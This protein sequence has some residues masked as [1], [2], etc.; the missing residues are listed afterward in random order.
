M[1]SFSKSSIKAK[2]SAS[3]AIS[4]A[5]IVAVATVALVELWGLNAMSARLTENW[6][7]EMESLGQTKRA[8]DEH[9]VLLEGRIS[10][11]NF[12]QIAFEQAKMADVRTRVDE[13]IRAFAAVADDHEEQVVIERFRADWKNYLA[14]YHRVIDRLDA[15]D[16]RGARAEFDSTTRATIASVYKTLDELIVASR[17]EGA[18]AAERV[19]SVFWLSLALILGIMLLGGLIVVAAIHWISSNV[20][21][22]ILNISNAMRR[23]AQGDES[24]A[25]TDGIGRVDE[26]GVLGAA[27]S[28]YRESLIRIRHLAEETS[29]ERDRLDTALANMSQGLCM[30]DRDGRLVIF[31]ERFIEIYG[32]PAGKIAAGMTTREIMELS[33]LSSKVTDADPEATLRLRDTIVREGK[34]GVF[35]QRLTDGRSVSISYRPR[36]QGG[37]VV[38]FEDITEHLRAEE[39]IRHLAQFDALTDLPNRVTFYEAIDATLTHLRRADSTAILSLDLDHFKSVNDTLGHP[40]GD[41]LLK[42]AAERMRSCVRG[43]DI[44]ARLGGDEFAIVQVPA[45]DAT[46]VTALAARLIEAVGAPYDIDG[47]QVVVGVSIG[48]AIAPNDGH[49]P[50]VLMKNADLAL[51]RAKAD[52]GGAYRFF[53]TEMDARMQA[54]RALELDLRKAVV[55]GEFE[56]YY[57]PIVDVKTQQITSCEALVRWHHPERGIVAPME[58]I[59]LA[60]ETSLIVPIGE[61]VLRQAC[62]EAAGWPAHVTVAVNLSPAQ[63]KSHGLVQTVTSALAD[64]RLPP[65][66]LE[67]EI[68]ELVLLQDN[69]GTFAILHEL[70]DLGIRIAMDDFGTG[71]S[72]LGYL[73]S[74]PFSKI[75]IDK[76]F[77]QDL[78]LKEDSIAIIRAVVGLGSSMGITTTAEGVETKDQFV[79]LASEGCNEVQGFLF[80]EPRPS[81]EIIGLIN[82]LTP[83]LADVA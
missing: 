41:S 18:E 54:R 52:G 25:V 72:S 28:G 59:P 60:E 48:I 50:D 6:L 65:G 13:G 14:S 11:T 45:Q 9:Q 56:L 21:K 19:Q 37:F 63:F 30:F 4:L 12:R 22:P 66:R 68:T 7:P 62:T 24:V 17:A 79:R 70:R 46:S 35:V 74:F 78:P 53:E 33:A 40:V 47:H 2:L 61:W 23:L 15:G 31:N 1:Q 43:D 34:S 39:R 8:I 64:S 3:F 42:A 80:S 83:Q 29:T 58:F 71:Y 81:N 69:N 49:E 38:T 36:P 26:I 27:V 82:K 57:Q 77:V 51:Y 5:L 44:V 32:L 67:L 73:R 20:S 55:N 75:K 76:S 16:P 10:T